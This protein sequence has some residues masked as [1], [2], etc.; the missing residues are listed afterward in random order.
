[1][2]QA[3][4]IPAQGQ[5]DPRCFHLISGHTIPSVGLGTWRSGSKA[6]DA[7][8][9]AIT[10]AGYRHVDTAAEYG[11]QEEVGHGLAAAMQAGI[12]RKDLFITSKIWC[13]DLS[14]DRVR[15]A[16]KTTLQD[17]QLDYLDLY[18][19]HWPIHLK[20]GAHKPPE[21]EEVQDFD[22]EG[23]WREME[24]LVKDGLVRDI[25]VCNF[26][27][28]KLD[29]LLRIAQTMPSVCQVCYLLFFYVFFRALQVMKHLSYYWTNVMFPWAGAQMEM[30]P[31]WRNDKMLEAC[32]KNGI[33]VTAYS[34]LGSQDDG[35]DLIHDPTVTEVANK[36][37][38]TPGQVLV[39]W[40]LQRGT[41]V[42]PKSTNAERI[43]E[44]IQV[45]GWE[46]P[47]EEFRALSSIRDQRRVLDGEDI[48]VNKTHGP[49]RCAADL[50]DNED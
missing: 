4:L 23:V 38:K 50:W 10:E 1:M 16:L 37:N 22:M 39:R 12:D 34:P 31:G 49:Y 25:G 29:K 33:H 26:T 14:P 41:S 13:S 48:F 11:V 32:K 36:L 18:L 9:T 15:T 17:L 27:L 5:A 30:H 43:K 6:S 20:G 2:A 28:K 3:Q 21:A 8:F 46:I 19:I 24:Q 42:I 47:E 35:R 7:V 44:N 45:F 40:A